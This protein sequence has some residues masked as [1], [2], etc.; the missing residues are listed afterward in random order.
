MKNF[1][2][3]IL[4]DNSKVTI[5]KNYIV[6]IEPLPNGKTRITVD[7]STNN[8]DSKHFFSSL[9]YDDLIKQLD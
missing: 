8:S 7:I 2:E 6:L 3:L 9:S 1:I 5:S 4:Q